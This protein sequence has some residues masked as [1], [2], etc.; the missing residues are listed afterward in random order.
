MDDDSVW[1]GKFAFFVYPD[2]PPPE[3]LGLYVLSTDNGDSVQIQWDSTALDKKDNF[4]STTAT[5]AI[6]IQ[7]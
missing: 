6:R 3:P 4:R 1:S 5:P 2:G 7:Y